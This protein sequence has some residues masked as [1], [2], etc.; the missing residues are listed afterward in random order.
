M[1][2]RNLAEDSFTLIEAGKYLLETGLYR[3]PS[4]GAAHAALEYTLPS[5]PVG[6]PL[7]LAGVFGIFGASEGVA[8][9]FTVTVSSVIAPLTAALAFVAFRSEGLAILAGTFAAIH[10]LALGF[11]GQVFTNNLSAALFVAS[12]YCLISALAVD[13][14][15]GGL[16]SLRAVQASRGRQW[17]FG[18]AFFLFGFMLAVRDTAIMFA[19]AWG[20][21]LYRSERNSFLAGK[22]NWAARG[23]C[24][25]IGGGALLA[26]WAPSLYFNMVNFGW[27]VVSTHYQTGIRLSLDYLL[28]GSDRFFGLPGIAVMSI[29]IVV[30]HFPFFGALPL[31][32][33]RFLAVRPFLVMAALIIVPLLSVNGAFPVASAGAGPRYVLPLVPFTAIVSAYALCYGWQRSC[34]GGVV[35][36]ASLI[37]V[38]QMLLTYPP[39]FLFHLWSRLGYLTYYSPVYVKYP[40]HNYP[41]HTNAVVQWVRENTPQ[42]ALIVTPSRAQHFFYYG[43]REVV[44]MS[45]MSLSDWMSSVAKR[46][47]YLVEDRN[48]A[49][50]SAPMETLKKKLDLEGITLRVAGGVEVFTPERGDIV[51]HIYLVSPKDG[52][53]AGTGL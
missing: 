44:I 3:M 19:P 34:K 26:G 41:D 40:Y 20:Y 45:A 17:R 46:P 5:W 14:G 38:W 4:V 37:L 32:R 42:T 30:Y 25:L 8:R 43:N 11:S 49:V 16:V 1:P 21:M 52:L 9:I 36:V 48:V 18:L 31:L 10:P 2:S 7:T 24:L 29:I 13:N 51:L 27:P 53:A 33:K 35:L 12:L 47:V 50:N 23:N 22:S 15:R 28:K 39:A 6:F